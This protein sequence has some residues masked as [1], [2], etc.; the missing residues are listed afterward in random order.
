MSKAWRVAIVGTG[1]AGFFLADALTNGDESIEVDLF[2]RLPVPYGLVRYGIAPDHPRI[3]NVGKIFERILDRPQVRFFGGIEV[4]TTVSLPELQERYD[5][6]ALAQG[7][8]GHRRLGIAGEDLPGSVAAP[9]VVGWY[10]G[11]PD[12]V[13]CAPV[14][15]CETAVVIGNGNVA[16]DVARVL[17][18]DPATLAE[19]SDAP[20]SVIAHLAQSKLKRIIV[21]G[22]RGPVQNAFGLGD[23]KE[24]GETPGCVATVRA[25]DLELDQE[26]REELTAEGKT[27]KQRNFDLLK[28]YSA[29]KAGGE[30]LVEFRFC[31][32][33]IEILGEGRVTG[34]TVVRNRLSGQPGDRRAESTG[35]T[36]TIPCGLVI[37]CIGYRGT[38]M[39]GV[40]YD[41]ASS[42]IPNLDGRVLDAMDGNPVQ[43]LYAAGWIRRGPVGLIG[44]NKKDSGA[45]A[46]LIRADLISSA[47]PS[48]AADPDSVALWLAERGE[49]STRDGWRAIDAAEITAGAGRAREKL[50]KRD[51][52][53]QVASTSQ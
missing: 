34:V 50:L 26:D 3:K 44:V 23:L 31:E 27:L 33:P 42:T 11:H 39:P 10:N 38:A 48:R 46:E 30:R 4:G 6:V 15:D 36:E 49:F 24:I 35:E 43:G 51:E 7:M 20:S 41:E 47:K 8:S 1:P 5:A 2:E 14:L 53:M 18:R 37:R 22:R 25:A 32:S 29:N 21:L 19:S 17:A 45:V 9:E 12:F 40:P 16:L 28:G 52:M 13:A